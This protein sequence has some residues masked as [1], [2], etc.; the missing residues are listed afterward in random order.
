M[1]A[2]EYTSLLLQQCA[3]L[4][5]HPDQ[6]VAAGAAIVLAKHLPA[7]GHDIDLDIWQELVRTLADR[8]AVPRMAKF[9]GHQKPDALDHIIT[10]LRKACMDIPPQLLIEAESAAATQARTAAAAPAPPQP[11]IEAE[12][13]AAAQAGTAAAAPVADVEADTMAPTSVDRDRLR[14]DASAAVDDS[15]TLPDLS[16]Q[17]ED[18]RTQPAGSSSV[19]VVDLL[20]DT[21]RQFTA[22]ARSRKQLAN[23]APHSAASDTA[24]SAAEPTAT[25]AARAAS[26][27]RK[28]A[29]P[30]SPR[31][32]LEQLLRLGRAAQ[33][34]RVAAGGTSKTKQAPAAAA[35]NT[36]QRQQQAALLLRQTAAVLLPVALQE[37]EDNAWDMGASIWAQLSRRQPPNTRKQ[38]LRAGLAAIDECLAVLRAPNDGAVPTAA[39]D[40]EGAARDAFAAANADAAA[41]RLPAGAAVQCLEALSMLLQGLTATSRHLWD[42]MAM[43]HFPVTVHLAMELQHRLLLLVPLAAAAAAAAPAAAC[44]GLIEAAAASVSTP[45]G[46]PAQ[47]SGRMCELIY[48]LTARLDRVPFAGAEHCAAQPGLEGE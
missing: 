18:V 29:A 32:P 28:A 4:L 39:A 16:A 8:A 12:S 35:G 13:A 5:E 31:D 2:D 45:A 36:A 41:Q 27:T 25:A 10:I 1:P 3:D 38:Q 20:L 21:N 30:E 6:T 23:A 46:E 26:P 14:S 34:V 7:A 47:I 19:R 33:K 9:I 48:S 44:D 11:L 43:S 42:N 15:G 17:P 37:E 24:A 22:A 40:A